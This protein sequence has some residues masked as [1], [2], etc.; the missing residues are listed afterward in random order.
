MMW[1]MMAVTAVVLPGCAAA[2]AVEVT[3]GLEGSSSDES[4]DLP[5]EP[6]LPFDGTRVLTLP[7]LDARSTSIRFGYADYDGDGI[8]D[9]VAS[10]QL[11][12]GTAPA[13]DYHL[14]AFRLSPDD[15]VLDEL[16]THRLGPDLRGVSPGHVDP[17]G[18]MDAVAGEWSNLTQIAIFQDNVRVGSPTYLP[19]HP[20]GPLIDFD[21]DGRIDYLSV[22]DG[23]I[24]T[25]S[26]DHVGG[27]TAGPP[28]FLGCAPSNALWGDM[29]GD[30]RL[31]LAVVASCEQTTSL[32]VLAQVDD[33][34]LQVVS[35]RLIEYDPSVATYVLADFDDDQ[36]LDFATAV[37]HWWDNG[38]H[39]RVTV[40]AGL[41]DGDFG[42]MLLD[43][44]GGTGFGGVSFGP[45]GDYDGDGVAESLVNF[46]WFE[47][48]PS[49]WASVQLG[50]D[51]LAIHE[52]PFDGSLEA[53]ADL[54]GDG[55]DEFVSERGEQ[56]VV[57]DLGCE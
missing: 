38:F 56:L 39:S 20:L 2:D 52:V 24:R 35:E 8:D 4:G 55:C 14:S 51:G 31:D 42:G 23:V 48:Q 57:L 54:D 41:G 44:D 37:G 7:I 5:A 32:H 13:V 28:I 6:I 47:G 19:G 29:T 9:V 17:N 22:S 40:R 12:I 1:A 45:V 10:Y 33:G 26:V 49:G 3:A 15:E 34:E 16:F 25:H 50:D 27:W 46:D 43:L 30:G 53:A 18:Y 21:A 36:I 11:Q